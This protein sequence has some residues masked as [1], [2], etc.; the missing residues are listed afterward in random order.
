MGTTHV[1]QYASLVGLLF[2]LS[3]SASYLSIRNRNRSG[4]GRRWEQIADLLFVVGLV[5]ISLIS[6]F[7][8]YE[9]I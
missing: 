2:L 5:C 1:D 4:L 3:A 9:V 8:A 6:I 7:F